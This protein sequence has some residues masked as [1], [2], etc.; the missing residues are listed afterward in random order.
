MYLYTIYTRKH[1]GWQCGRVRPLGF[2][3][4]SLE[5]SSNFHTHTHTRKSTF[6]P[7]IEPFW[8]IFQIYCREKRG[9]SVP[10]TILYFTFSSARPSVVLLL[11]SLLWFNLL[12]SHKWWSACKIIMKRMEKNWNFCTSAMEACLCGPTQHRT[13]CMKWCYVVRGIG[14]CFIRSCCCCCFWWYCHKVR[15]CI[16]LMWAP[17]ANTNQ[18]RELKPNRF[19][20]HLVDIIPLCRRTTESQPIYGPFR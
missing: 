2:L 3:C 5:G 1:I 11:S 6:D 12:L 18:G 7:F 8:V 19:M 15:K 20:F 14:R 10:F 16:D 4:L 9:F 13:T 17:D